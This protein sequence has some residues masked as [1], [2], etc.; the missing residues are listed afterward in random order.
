MFSVQYVSK[1]IGSMLGMGTMSMRVNALSVLNSFYEGKRAFVQEPYAGPR[2]YTG[3]EEIQYWYVNVGKNLGV[4]YVVAVDGCNRYEY[5]DFYCKASHAQLNVQLCNGNPD[6]G[7]AQTMMLVGNS[8]LF[9]R[10]QGMVG[11]VRD[12]VESSDRTTQNF[13]C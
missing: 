3:H 4:L 5:V 8:E 10:V 2:K 7:H 13:E 1:L 12:F 6:S 11:Q 9:K